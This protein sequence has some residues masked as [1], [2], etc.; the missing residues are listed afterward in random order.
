[1]FIRYLLSSLLFCLCASFAAAQGISDIRLHEGK[2]IWRPAP[3]PQPHVII[4][5]HKVSVAIHDE[6]ATTT[7]RQTFRS[8]SRYILEGIYL[9]PIPA[10]AVLKDFAMTM[11][12]K[13][14][15]GEVLESDKARRIYEGIVRRNRDPGL[16]EYVGKRLFRARV[17]PLNPGATIDIE[18]SYVE[19][20][21]REGN[22]VEYRYPLKTQTF[23][24]GSVTQVSV[25]VAIETASELKTV[26]SSSHD[27][28]K[29][30][31]GDRKMTCSYEAKNS[32]AERD[33]QLYFSRNDRAF[34]LDLLTEKSGDGQGHF[35]MVLAP[36]Q[37]FTADE[38]LPKDVVFVVD[39]SGSMREDEKMEQAKNALQYGIKGLNS[40]DRFSIV[41][42]STEARPMKP[43]LTVV[44]KESVAAAIAHIKGLEA[45][46][47]TNIHEALTSAIR[48][49]ASEDGRVNILVFLT[50]GRATVGETRMQTI[51][52]EV[53]TSS[54]VPLRLFSFGV[55]Y[56]VNTDLLDA[57]ADQ[58]RGTRDYVT[59]SQNV[60]VV[61]SSFFDKIANPVMSD[62]E[63]SVDGVTITDVYPKRLP[64]LFKGGEITIF[65]RYEGTGVKAIRL[66]GRIGNTKKEYVFEGR[67]QSKSDGR[68]F[69]P[70]LWAK[71][72]VGYLWDQI[73]ING[74]QG[75]LRDEIVR[76]G[77]KYGIVTPF[78]S[79]LV[80]EDSDRQQLRRT[81][82]ASRLFDQRNRSARWGRLGGVSGSDGK[83]K[84]SPNGSPAPGSAG[85]FT[86]GGAV[87]AARAKAPV[88]LVTGTKKDGVLDSLVRK[89]LREGGPAE[90]SEEERDQ[91]KRVRIKRFAARSFEMRQGTWVDV[92]LDKKSDKEREKLLK[93]VKPFSTEYFELIAKHKDLSKLLAAMPSLMIEL[94]HQ[95]IWVLP[96]ETP[97]PPVK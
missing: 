55:G 28:G 91:A 81:D 12:G 37:N 30:R 85:G 90:Q 47:G 39:T 56:D 93:K 72:K 80:L 2:R 76:L 60:E 77:K 26:F 70:L 84:D 52:K 75:E 3:R 42:F 83:A 89:S 4:S 59:P 18:L 8:K 15:K 96:A 94:G 51:L 92:A 35:M 64:D 61:L 17:F 1:M 62:L 10:D 88:N 11:N 7:V 23:R 14:V 73:R 79:Y 68:D 16:L 24:H 43:G 19:S 46:G 5:S 74:K 57:L 82:S 41:S 34:G 25:Q 13:M 66:E 48:G 31:K 87:P 20:L 6:I 29:V 33:F 65:G 49:F 78:T 21:R 97:A 36:K 22:L 9:F 54:K 53:K 44:S 63:I 45:R 27:I 95:I 58:N 40:N 50:D 69:I 67:F 32:D 71:R 86:S 38:I